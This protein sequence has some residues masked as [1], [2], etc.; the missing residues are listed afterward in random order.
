M[1]N[2]AVSIRPGRNT[3]EDQQSVSVSTTSAKTTNTIGRG[4]AVVYSTVECFIVVGED[5]TATVAAGMPIPA[6][7]LVP[8]FG[9]NSTDKIAAITASG[10]GILY[11]RPRA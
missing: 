10:T 11:I 1:H 5:P 8:I 6:N 9:F 7:T 4:R 2:W 3:G